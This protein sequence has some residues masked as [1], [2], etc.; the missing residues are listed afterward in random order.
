MQ[1]YLCDGPGIAA[2]GLPSSRLIRALIASI[3]AMLLCRLMGVL[4]AGAP[5]SCGCCTD[6]IN[7]RALVESVP[8]GPLESRAILCERLEP[9]GLTCSAAVADCAPQS[10]RLLSR[11]D[12]WYGF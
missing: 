4:C 12:A 11:R 7:G 10:V 8:H 3:A 1:C 6:G 9:L 2:Y 5:C